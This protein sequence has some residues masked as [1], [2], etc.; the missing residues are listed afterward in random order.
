M[1]LLGFDP[2][3]PPAQRTRVAAVLVLA[4]LGL[5]SSAVLV[6]GMAA[7]PLAIAAWRTLGAGLLLSWAFPAGLRTVGRRDALAIVAAGLLLGLHFWTWFASVQLTTVLRSTLLVCLVPGWT[8][9]LEWLLHRRRPGR[10]TLLGLLVALPGLALLA[11]DGGRG[12]LWGD[13]LATFAGL[14][15]SAYLLVGRD[16]RRRVDVSTYMGLVCL[17]ASATL[18]AAGIGAGVALTGFPAATWGLVLL[19]ILGPQLLGHQGFAYAVRWVPA[20]TLSAVTL[21]EPVGAA[22]LA[23]AV[24]RE[25]PGPAALVGSAIVLAGTWLATRP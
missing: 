17:S 8:A 6:R 16:V 21:L 19:A 20:S 22:L 9:V 13:A 3:T 14:L 25:V 11:G 5:S 24:L 15:W 7:D 1:D 4:L 18:F 2:D 10:G 12:S 23:A